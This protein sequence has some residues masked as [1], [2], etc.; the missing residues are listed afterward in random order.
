MV[1]SVVRD[2]AIIAKSTEEVP[3]LMI[4][5]SV[6]SGILMVQ[7]MQNGVPTILLTN[8]KAATLDVHPVAKEIRR[9]ILMRN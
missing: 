9:N 4:L 1:P 2:I 7:K 3:T 5:L 6:E 8:P